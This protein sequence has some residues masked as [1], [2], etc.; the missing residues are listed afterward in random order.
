MTWDTLPK[1]IKN[2]VMNYGNGRVSDSWKGSKEHSEHGGIRAYLCFAKQEVALAVGKL[3]DE[4]DRLQ[5]IE[6]LYQRLQEVNHDVQVHNEFLTKEV[7]RL[8]RGD[9]TPEEF[10]NLCH[11][12]HDKPGCTP[13]EFAQGCVG[14]NKEL[15]GDKSCLSGSPAE[16]VDKL[17]ETL[18]DKDFEWVGPEPTEDKE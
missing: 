7:A 10:Q 1:E 12:R 8:K 4:I 3:V 17:L 9:F 14:Y 2:A 13:L 16:A 15:F 11:N 6:G 5:R 18:D